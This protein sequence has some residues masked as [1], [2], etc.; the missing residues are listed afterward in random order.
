MGWG[1]TRPAKR[2]GKHI[3]FIIYPCNRLLSKVP[4]MSTLYGLVDTM[5][6]LKMNQFHLYMEH[7]F[8]FADHK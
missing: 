5:V 6:R 3:I 4:T 8:A 1:K 7:T 2:M